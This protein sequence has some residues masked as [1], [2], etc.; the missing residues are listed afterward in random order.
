MTEE[1]RKTD[2]ESEEGKDIQPLSRVFITLPTRP[3]IY[4]SLPKYYINQRIIICLLRHSTLFN[5][6][7]LH[8]TLLSLLSTLHFLNNTLPA[9]VLLLRFI[10]SFPPLP[11]LFLFLPIPSHKHNHPSSPCIIFFPL[12]SR[13]ASP[14][15][16]PAHI[17]SC[18]LTLSAVAYRNKASCRTKVQ[19][20][21]TKFWRN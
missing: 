19:R 4:V 7:P 15:L 21:N 14:S 9:S 6:I 16:R 2:R 17:A 13:A 3:S 1:E 8:S 11:F 20:V 10:F 18:I 5:S 12:L